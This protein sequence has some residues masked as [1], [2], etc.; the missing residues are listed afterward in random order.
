MEQWVSDVPQV[1]QAILDLYTDVDM[2]RAQY[3]LLGARLQK[4]IADGRLRQRVVN[5]EGTMLDVV[6][7][8]AKGKPKSSRNRKRAERRR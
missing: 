1:S 2:M 6:A 7:A 5:N 3:L 8:G 4:R